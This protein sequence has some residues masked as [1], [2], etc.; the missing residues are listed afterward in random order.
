MSAVPYLEQKNKNMRMQ[1][2]KKKQNI[3]LMGIGAV[4]IVL[5]LTRILKY[6]H[7]T[8]RII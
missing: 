5:L 1:I 7:E 3:G 4:V 6:R 8:F 2:N